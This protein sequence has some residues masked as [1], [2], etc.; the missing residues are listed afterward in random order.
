MTLA[1]DDLD[2]LLDALAARAA[3]RAAGE[4]VNVAGDPVVDGRA[5]GRVVVAPG[6]AI[7]SLWGNLTFDQTTVTFASVAERDAQWA[8][9]QAGATCYTEADSTFWQRKGPT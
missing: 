8:N 4:L 1:A 2:A 5:A 6:E 9:P 3:E 7:V